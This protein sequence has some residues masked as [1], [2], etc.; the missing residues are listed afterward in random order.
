[1]KIIPIEGGTITKFENALTNEES[2]ILFNFV[3]AQTNREVDPNQVPWNQGNILFYRTIKDPEIRTIIKKHR[4]LMCE[5][6]EKV[7]GNKV[8]PHLTTIVL[9]KPGQSM[10]RHTDQGDKG[11]PYDFYMRAL[12]S[13]I[14]LNDNFEGG[15]TF[16]RN[17]SLTDQSWKM[18]PYATDGDYISKPKKGTGIIFYGDD[19]NAHG[20]SKLISGDRATISTWFTT[21]PTQ[22]QE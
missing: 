16:I 22:E 12:T 4:D 3:K 1:M 13:V 21:D 6:I 14:Y 9:W 18:T 5:N 10:G 7:Y 20:V 15:E 17:N 19:R 8:Y 2:D 11:G